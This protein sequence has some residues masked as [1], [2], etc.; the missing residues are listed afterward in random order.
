[1]EHLPLGDLSK[2]ISEDIREH[3][4]KDISSQLLEGLKLM[5]SKGFTH[6]D[7][8]PQVWNTSFKSFIASC[9]G[10]LRHHRISLSSKSSHHGG[11]RS[12]ILGLQNVLGTVMRP[13]FGLLREHRAM[14]LLR[15]EAM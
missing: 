15:S 7:L 12:V 6:R 5:H 3:D 9:C 4:L 1:M 8:K 11:L 10:P 2:H 13:N 14:R